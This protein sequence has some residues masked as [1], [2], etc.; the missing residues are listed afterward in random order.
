MTP[1]PRMAL[2][3]S[4]LDVVDVGTVKGKN[5]AAANAL[6]SR[7]RGV[8]LARKVPFDDLDHSQSYE[9]FD[10][11]GA[12][13]QWLTDNGYT[14]GYNEFQ[15]S[16][17]F[18]YDFYAVDGPPVHW[19]FEVANMEPNKLY[20]TPKH[21]SFGGGDLSGLKRYPIQ[22]ALVSPSAEE[23]VMHLQ[24][25]SVTEEE[26]NR[27][28]AAKA[29]REASKYKATVPPCA[30]VYPILLEVCRFDPTK[31]NVAAHSRLRL[32]LNPRE[33]WSR[34]RSPEAMISALEI[35]V[36]IGAKLDWPHH[37]WV[38]DQRGYS[39][40][41]CIEELIK[42]ENWRKED[43]RNERIVQALLQFKDVMLSRA[44]TPPQKEESKTEQA[45]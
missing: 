37:D 42:Y 15:G 19:R 9:L 45:A 24:I 11:E 21:P 25:V 31:F 38:A 10:N 17:H 40:R 32:D 28:L 20:L 36:I 3:F 16:E 30:V 39:Y 13:D 4:Y 2:T 43:P 35:A 41:E 34:I 29:R 1:L 18:R 22:V 26:K 12:A 14:H 7:I 8:R 23:V 27:K 33:Y 5:H 6:L 44:A